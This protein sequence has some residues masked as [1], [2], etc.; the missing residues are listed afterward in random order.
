MLFSSSYKLFLFSRYLSFC[1][2]LS[3]W[4]CRKRG[5]IRKIKLTAKFMT[6]KP[7]WQT[8]AI[9]MLPNISRSKA[10]QTM[11]LGQRIEYN[12]INIFLQ[13]L[14]RKWGRGTSHRTFLIY[15]YIS[16]SIFLLFIFPDLLFYFYLFIS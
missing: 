13:K 8:I 11:K 5:L 15:F 10:N 12:K 7:G 6:W 2:C 16:R 1:L 14:C 4:S 3:F 9:N